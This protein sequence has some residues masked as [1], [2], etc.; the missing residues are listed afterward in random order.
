MGKQDVE[1]TQRRAGRGT[2]EQRGI[3][4]GS[5]GVKSEQRRR[6]DVDRFEDGADR[7]AQP[8]QSSARKIN[9]PLVPPKP[10]EFDSAT[11]IGICRATFGT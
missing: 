6:I 7:S 9:E 11:R 8:D 10:N 2:F 1:T 5:G 3:Q 4:L